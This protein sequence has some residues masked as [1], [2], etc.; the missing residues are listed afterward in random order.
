MSLAARAARSA[1][2]LRSVLDR[3]VVGQQPLKDALV[4]S[5]VSREHL[6]VEGPPGIGKTALAEAA[7]NA[8]GKSAFFAQLHRDTRLSE[9][10]GDA[11]IKREM[12]AGG[13]VIRSDVRAGA[14][15]TAEVAVLD[16]ISRAPGEALNV[17]LRLLNER[18]YHSKPI[19]LWSAVA[20]GNPTSAEFY[21]EPLDP[22]TLDRF[23]LQLRTEGLV[24][25]GEWEDAASVMDRFG[26]SPFCT[27][28]GD[29]GSS[30]DHAA[31]DEEAAG[32]ID[33]EL[34]HEALLH[35]PLTEP[36]RDALLAFLTK[37]RQRHALDH[38]NSLLTDRT[39]LTRAPKIIRAAAVVAGREQAHPDD[40]HVLRLLTT[41]RVPEEVQNDGIDSLIEEVADEARQRL[42]QEQDKMLGG[43]GGSGGNGSGGG[44]GDGGPPPPD[45]GGKQAPSPPPEQQTSGKEHNATPRQREPP[46]QTSRQQ[47]EDELQRANAAAAA[48]QDE[49]GRNSAIPQMLARLL[50]L[51]APPEREK[52]VEIN[53]DAASVRGLLTLIDVLKGQFERHLAVTRVTHTDGVPR[54]WRRL[55]GL[56][57]FSEDADPI[58]AAE[59]M[60]NTPAELPDAVRRAKPQRGG[61]LA[62]C[63]DVSTSMHGINAKYASSL[64]LRVIELA[65]RRRMRVAVLEY[66]DEV[67]ALRTGGK[68]KNANGNGEDDDINGT[69]ESK[70]GGGNGVKEGGQ[71][72]T[73]DYTALRAF[74]RRLECG[75]LTDYEAPIKLTL[76]EF[77]ADR[78]L[79]SPYVP[80]HVLFITDG[81]PTKGDR[82]CVEARKRMRRAG[83]QLHTLFVEPE[84]EAEYP[85]LLA[86]LAD[87]SM[88]V[89]MRASV[90]DANAG[91]IEVSVASP[92]TQVK[93][94]GGTYGARFENAR[95][96]G[97]TGVDD[98]SGFGAYPSLKKLAK[99]MNFQ[100]F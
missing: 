2:A 21:N 57:S 73:T 71:F 51:I 7:V 18:K 77:A 26:D 52:K 29:E 59:W 27:W 47:R 1:A 87:D 89:R 4:L 9:L 11:V 66:S 97:L 70:E 36:V 85:P 33:L 20:T 72:F 3:R 23:A 38:S 14:L 93:G 88:G 28:Q 56:E 43:G 10:I 63:R 95:R 16:D 62:I 54:G 35:V 61:A 83:V 98:L 25:G 69:S 74:A 79:R 58:H 42:Q 64:A 46:Q 17:L 80:K 49:G 78:R 44:N 34:L 30:V 68:C 39:F 37:L 40:L 94:G 86:A 65:E 45:G 100:G 32:T 82:R 84:P 81:H 5:L 19:P 48:E 24:G 76:D 8:T 15:L 31:A 67:H 75:G 13:E 22:A 6:Y 92:S 41:F 99:G 12:D 50:R 91:V 55:R 53:V 96:R 90:V 60:R